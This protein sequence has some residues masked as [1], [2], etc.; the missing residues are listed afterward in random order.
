[1]VAP[2]AKRVFAVYHSVDNPRGDQT[3]E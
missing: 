2:D 1:M 3:S